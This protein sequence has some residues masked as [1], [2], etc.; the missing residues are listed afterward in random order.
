MRGPTGVGV[1]WGRRELLDA[2]P[3]FLGGG[4]MIADVRMSGPTY[5]ALPHKYEAGTPPIAQAA[6]SAP[7]LT[8]CPSSAWT[9]SPRTSAPLRRTR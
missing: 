1:L 7:R 8:T 6:G 3:P 2:L 4:E 9:P 5:A